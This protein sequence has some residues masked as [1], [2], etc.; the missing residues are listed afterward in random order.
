[1]NNTDSTLAASLSGK[2]GEKLKELFLDGLKDIYW[3]EQQLV[4]TL[5]I[6]ASAATSDELK[7]AFNAHLA[8]TE[9]HVMRVEKVFVQLGEE[10]VAK[11]CPAIEGLIREGNEII[12]STETGSFVRDSGLIMAAQKVEHYEIASYGSLRTLAGL[13]GHKNEAQLLQSILD[14]ENAADRKLTN[15][16]E[17]QIN[18]EAL[19]E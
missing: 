11:L 4:N 14:E 16:A 15:I 10:P 5:P 17:G 18:K 7:S 6:L 13:L 1:M 12:A 2:D 3:A 9:G 19:Q 8:D